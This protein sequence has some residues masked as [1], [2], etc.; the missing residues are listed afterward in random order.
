[1][2]GF[3]EELTDLVN[4]HS[5]EN[6]SNTP[7]YILAIFMC[8]CLKAFDQAV[9]FRTDWYGEKGKKDERGTAIINYKL[10]GEE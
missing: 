3:R 8:N 5:M 2:S 9:T 6:G 1:M 7:D 4:R 10:E